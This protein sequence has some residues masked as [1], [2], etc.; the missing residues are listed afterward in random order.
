MQVENLIADGSIDVAASR[1]FGVAGGIRSAATGALLS[2]L[3]Q[4]YL[5]WTLLTY[6]IATVFGAWALRALIQG[7]FVPNLLGLNFGRSSVSGPCL[8]WIFGEEIAAKDVDW[9]RSGFFMGRFIVYAK[10][11]RRIYTRLGWYGVA[12]AEIERLW[13]DFRR[14]HDPSGQLFD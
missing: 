10:D 12:A 14:T 2:W 5:S 6:S 9:Q 4:T 3:S 8:W 13:E 7:L 11:D 1:S